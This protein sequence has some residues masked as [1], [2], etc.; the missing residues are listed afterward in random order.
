MAL[1]Q[2]FYHVAIAVPDLDA[3]ME[4]LS[5]TVGLSWGEAREA[6]YPDGPIRFTYSVDGP[7]HIELVQ[8]SPGSPWDAA[9]GARFD[10]IGFWSSSLDDD[11]RELHDRGMPIEV[12]GEELGNPIFS[13][14]RSEISGLRVE[15]VTEEMR[16]HVRGGPDAAASSS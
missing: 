1:E 8:G 11:K 3:A 5:R 12:D 16:P 4:E 15:L 2:P 6:E 14:H 13:Y 9:D 7:P 10:H